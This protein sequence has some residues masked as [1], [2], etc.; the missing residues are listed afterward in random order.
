MKKKAIFLF[1]LLFLLPLECFGIYKWIDSEGIPHF[2]DYPPPEGTEF[3][4][5][6][7]EVNLQALSDSFDDKEVDVSWERLNQKGDDNFNEK[8]N[9][10]S[11]T[12]TSSGGTD[13]WDDVFTAPTIYK[14]FD[15]DWDFKIETKV[16]YK[17]NG[18][19]KAGFVLWSDAL[20]MY[21][22][23]TFACEKNKEIYFAKTIKNKTKA[24]GRVMAELESVYLR[25]QKKGENIAASYSKDGSAWADVGQTTI[26]F[27]YTV[28]IGLFS[29]SWGQKSTSVKF[30]YFKISPI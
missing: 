9:P 6:N 22:N 30:D 17:T 12:I 16:E 10:N 25:L 2:T 4:R 23:I 28:N 14:M 13:I 5:L 27:P 26:D 11:L 21:E 29:A 1:L 15:M 18:S 7:K 8:I 3:N 24:E 20:G 19:D